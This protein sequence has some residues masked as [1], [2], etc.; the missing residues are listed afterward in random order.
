MNRAAFYA[1]IILVLLASGLSKAADVT[2][3]TI[4]ISTPWVRATPKG[5][6][7][8]GGYMTIT[9]TG[10]T[11]E[12]LL[13][14]TSSLAR[15]FEIHEM[16]MDNGI[17]KMRPVAG[18]IE[19]KPGATVTFSPSGYHLMFVGLNAP[20]VRGEHVTAILQFEKAGKV[21]VNF[22]VEGLGAQT[23][24]S[25]MSPDMQHKP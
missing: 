3:G 5:A 16:S 2:I 22:T 15:R 13:G 14:G 4:K 24:D 11:P 23:G 6:A 8:G 9:N 1:A 18:G 25:S 17:M 20:F 21:T 19:I 10:N 12:R 7:V